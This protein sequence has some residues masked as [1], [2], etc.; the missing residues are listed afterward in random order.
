MSRSVNYIKVD[1]DH[2][3]LDRRQFRRAR[4]RIARQRQ[5]RRGIA[6]LIFQVNVQP[7]IDGMNRAAEAF[8]RMATRTP[9]RETAGEVLAE[10]IEEA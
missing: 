1:L 9:T 4:R 7:F 3:G 8:A 6:S 10:R 5:L 2:S